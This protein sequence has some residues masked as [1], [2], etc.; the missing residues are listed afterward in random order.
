M[1]AKH[2]SEGGSC[3][4]LHPVCPCDWALQP[5]WCTQPARWME[6]SVTTV[7]FPRLGRHNG[8]TGNSPCA[9]NFEVGDT[10]NKSRTML[11]QR[12]TPAT[13]DCRD[14][15][16]E[17]RKLPERNLAMELLKRLLEGEITSASPPT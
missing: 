4:G 10:F 5:A 14:F 17:A 7:S 6:E 1:P 8:K 2:L 13:S 12:R 9:K 15:L 16:N 3:D 11:N